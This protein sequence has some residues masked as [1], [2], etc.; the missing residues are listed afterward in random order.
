M[1]ESMSNVDIRMIA[2]EIRRIVEGSFIKN[3]YQ[4]G[5]VF[6]FKLYMPGEGTFQLLVEPGR[7]IHITEFHRRA[8]RTPPRFCSV[9]RKYLREQRVTS[10]TQHDF[11][12]IVVIRV[13]DGN[14]TY[15]VVAELFGN[16]NLLLLDGDHRVFVALRYKRMRDRDLLPK[17][18]YQF[19]P[20]RGTD[21]FNIDREGLERVLRESKANLV[22]TLASRLNLDGLSCEEICRIAG[23]DGI[24]QAATL[25]AATIDTVYEAI[26]RFR[27]KVEAGTVDPQVIYAPGDDGPQQIAFVPFEYELFKGMQSVQF[28]TFSK[29]VDEFF[30]VAD[31]GLQ[32]EE[33]IALR[34]ERQR[35]ERI[36]E[37]QQESIEALREQADMMRR[38]GEAIYAN[39]QVVS[40]I[41]DTIAKARASGVAWD[42]II[43]RIEEAKEQGHSTATVIERID[44]SKGLV[45]VRLDGTTVELD[46]RKSA[47]E[48]AAAAYERAKKSETKVRGAQEQVKR[49][50]HKLDSLETTVST[51]ETVR[52]RARIRKKRWY[53]K[54]RWFVSSEGFL[55]LG[56]RDAKSNER[57]A[58]RQMQPNDIFLHAVVHGAP[59]VVVK[60]PD[61]PPGEQTLYEAAQFAVTF[62]RAWQDG[63]SSADAYWVSPEQVSFSPPTGEY[64]PAGAV[65][66]YGKKNYIRNVPVELSVGVVLEDEYAVPVAG[67]PTAIEIHTT[68][69]VR[70]VP[71]TGKK[72][73]L[74]RDI[75][76]ALKRQVPDDDVAL[77]GNMTT[78]DLMQVLP[79]GGGMVA[80]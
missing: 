77:V 55:V 23:V 42:E 53:E 3:I 62:S 46:M 58:K 51:R 63:L 11:D 68:Y 14:D 64:L 65:M 9:L 74:V 37:K 67:P 39:F 25:S 71:G 28:P 69:H 6:V 34:R 2:P 70:V 56:G 54:Y 1:K 44:P 21:I 10:I 41:L 52:P 40:N 19:P 36:I 76:V 13:G 8:P 59:Y 27:G 57:L 29:A 79:A 38:M 80:E 15:E 73:Q 35:L 7:R 30:G 50:R 4:Y 5:D 33:D 61:Q 32:P 78:E 24:T 43:A 16:G 18:E 31:D 20:P 17:A 47:Q 72:G 45:V 12:R 26:D 22:R 75:L 49:A 66:I 48:N 60:V